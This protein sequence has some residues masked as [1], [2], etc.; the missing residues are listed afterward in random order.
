MCPSLLGPPSQELYDLGV[1][2]LSGWM[3]EFASKSERG[4]YFWHEDR[5]PV[6][7]GTIQQLLQR[8]SQTNHDWS[9][10]SQQSNELE[11]TGSLDAEVDALDILRKSRTKNLISWRSR[12]GVDRQKTMSHY[13]QL[14]GNKGFVAKMPI[15]FTSTT[16]HIETY[17]YV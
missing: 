10:L 15:I 1:R 14:S 13:I 8:V 2:R 16:N 4:V 5:V 17:T 9:R 6:R 7:G 12:V 11:Q 3:G